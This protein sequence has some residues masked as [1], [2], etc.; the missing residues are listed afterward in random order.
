MDRKEQTIVEHLSEFRTRFL[1]VL[2]WFFIIFCI[3]LLFSDSLY[4]YLTSG[5][6]QK[7]IVLG[8]NDILW[9]YISLASLAAF[10]LTL[11]FL[12]YQVWAFIRPALEMKEAQALTAYI[13]ATFICFV[14]GLAFGFY[15]VSPAI[16]Q[17]LLSL[18]ENLFDTQLTAENYLTF[19]F[20]TT[21]PIAI[22]FELPVI[23]AFLTSIG[24]LNPKYLVQYRRYAYFL[25]LVIAVMI[26]PADFISDLTMTIPLIFI[27]EVSILISKRIYRK[28]E[29]RKST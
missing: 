29:R 24:L 3:S 10:S 6:E 13:P 17:V 4:R 18:G 26:T 19:L 9:I 16:L 5:F 28:K 14:A 11:P 20:H 22:L 8:P 12:V 27:Y 2:G 25:L 21:L 15:L 7:L 1:W 23:V